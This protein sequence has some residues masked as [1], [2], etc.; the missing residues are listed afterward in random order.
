MPNAP[1]QGKLRVKALFAEVAEILVHLESLGI[2]SKQKQSSNLPRGIV[3]QR[4]D[5]P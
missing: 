5:G 2:P 4:A 1:F 3:I